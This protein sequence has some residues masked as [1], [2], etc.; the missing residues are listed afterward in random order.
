MGA[1]SFHDVGKGNT[2][3]EAYRAAVDDALFE[4]GHDA[5]NGTISTT[6][7]YVKIPL[8]EGEDPDL[9]AHRVLEDNRVQKWQDCACV[10][11]PDN[12]VL[13]HFAGW[14]AS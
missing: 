11:D 12:P 9:W 7:G 5:Y 8:E 3:A 2:A 6:S 14:A 4:W 13:W 10:E 1:Y